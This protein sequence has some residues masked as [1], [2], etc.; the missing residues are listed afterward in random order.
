M[1]VAQVMDSMSEEQVLDKIT[2]VFQ[3]HSYDAINTDQ[4]S[5]ETGIS[6]TELRQRFPDGKKQM[7]DAI[8]D[9]SDSQF[10][11]YILHSLTLKKDPIQRILEM[12][13]RLKTYYQN[14]FG[15][16]LL[17]TLSIG[18]SQE[19]FKVHITRSFNTW[20]N[21]LI[22]V[23]CDSG[24]TNDEARERAEQALVSIEGSLVFARITGNNKPF[25]NSLDNLPCLLT[26]NS[27]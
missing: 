8:L 5:S 21:A 25:Q 22:A 26:G 20:C 6:A 23:A 16:C 4:I 24:F 1:S 12:T 18:N 9:R 11:Q 14:G 17:E 3:S 27:C 19:E 13:G 7:V 2:Q 15:S 10:S